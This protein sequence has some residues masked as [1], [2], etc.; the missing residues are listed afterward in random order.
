MKKYIII[1]II[2]LML[3]PAAPAISNSLK[4]EALESYAYCGLMAM[5][6]TTS[7]TSPDTP[8]AP[9]KCNCKNGKVSYD[10]GTSWTDCPCKNGATCDCP[11]CPH[12]KKTA[13]KEEIE[14]IAEVER[15]RFPRTVLITQYKYCSWCRTFDREVVSLLRNEAHKKA[16][17]KVGNKR[18]DNFQII[19]LD[20]PNA[21]QEIEAL[22][23]EFLSLPTIFF[24]E[25]DG[26][27]KSVEGSM[28]YKA[29]IDWA[30]PSKKK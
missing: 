5:L 14:P 2:I 10:G 23:L 26:S 28:S 13:V 17:W 25:S 9:T 22:K 20:D 27:Y 3:L 18:S 21:E 11:G 7:K 19:D 8:D 6:P 15:D 1:L 4:A 24:L 30:K 12:C 16:G 29:Y